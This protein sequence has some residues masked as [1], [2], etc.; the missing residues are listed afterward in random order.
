M[1]AKYVE[2]LHSRRVREPINVVCLLQT[3]KLNI[4]GKVRQGWALEEVSAEDEDTAQLWLEVRLS[5]ATLQD[6]VP[7]SSL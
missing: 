4:L 3:A 5:K 7:C 2:L 6:E 1:P